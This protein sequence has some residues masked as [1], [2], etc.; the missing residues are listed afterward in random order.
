MTDETARK[1]ADQTMFAEYADASTDEVLVYE[2]ADGWAWRRTSRNGNIVS[3]DGG[4]GYTDKSFAVYMAESR[5][6]GILVTV[7]GEPEEAA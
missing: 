5:N 3:T 6:P 4:Q 2:A 7:D 1:Y